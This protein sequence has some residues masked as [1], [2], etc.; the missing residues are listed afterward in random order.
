[1]E[2]ELS[3]CD[4]YREITVAEL[5]VELRKIKDKDAEVTLMGV[6]PISFVHEL[7]SGKI[8]IMGKR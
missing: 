2:S 7:P 6:G 3:H 4:T 8:A 5:M 1:M